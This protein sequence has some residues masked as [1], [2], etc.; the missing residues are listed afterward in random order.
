MLIMF[1]NCLFLIFQIEESNRKHAE[2][3]SK[4]NIANKRVCVLIVFKYYSVQQETKSTKT[5]FSL[6]LSGQ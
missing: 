3:E 1:L 2:L 6:M 4:L 5:T